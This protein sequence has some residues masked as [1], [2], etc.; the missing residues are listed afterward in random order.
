MWYYGSFFND[1]SQ[2]RR[3]ADEAGHWSHIQA[4]AASCNMEFDR[5]RGMGEKCHVILKPYVA[6]K[7]YSILQGYTTRKEFHITP[8]AKKYS[9]GY[10]CSARSSSKWKVIV[11]NPSS[12]LPE[13]WKHRNSWTLWNVMSWCFLNTASIT[14]LKTNSGRYVKVVPLSI[15]VP[16]L[17]P[18]SKIWAGSCNVVPSTST[19]LRFTL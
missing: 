17:S 16:F 4:S 7:P 1:S 15:M 10:T 18:V 5:K 12:T 2:K 9:C 8:F 13:Y 3:K 14:S 11:G 6:L 19:D